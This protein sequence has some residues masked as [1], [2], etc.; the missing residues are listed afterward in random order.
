M[1]TCIICRLR[2]EDFNDEHVIPDSIG[3]YYHIRSVCTDC[4]SKLGSK[5][6]NKLTN[7][8]FIEFQRNLLQIK[9]KSGH[10]P[11]PLKGTYSIEGEPGYKVLLEAD[12][13]GQLTPRLLPSVSEINAESLISGFTIKIDKKDEKDM[14]KILDK[15]L[16][17]NGLDRSK[18]KSTI[19]FDEKHPWL[20]NKVEVDI[21][22]F[23]MA[24]L[25]IAYEFAV[26]K[27]PAYFD[28]AS[29]KTISNVL[30]NA[31]FKN[32]TK[33]VKFLGSGFDEKVLQP[34]KHLI[35][36][37]N[38]NHYLMLTSFRGG[39]LCIINLFSSFS[40]GILLSSTP[41]KL[42]GDV[43]IGKND[44]VNCTFDTF[45][46]TQL[47]DATFSPMEY[48][49]AYHF[50][51]KE[52]AIAFHKIESHPDFDFYY[53]NG[54]IPFYDEKGNVLYDDIDEKL[55]QSGVKK[56]FIGDVK[57]EHTTDYALN[58][59]VFIKVLPSMTLMPVTTVRTHRKLLNII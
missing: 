9:G 55:I 10:I 46:M 51:N 29:A 7:H 47:V 36:F 45:T 14:D 38:D 58:E 23:K 21:H 56:A 18:I 20:Y 5:I 8:L 41:Y 13:D 59:K 33:K 26:D 11:D 32:L 50:I 12:K 42:E 48:R 37:K 4:N 57:K 2:K 19:T 40:I 6:D 28:D 27:V 53:E 52:A 25:K 1:K 22:D 15:V 49:F 39:F 31:D 43:I 30:F 16:K 34:F 3:G 54:K 44:I 17:R 35:D 24:M